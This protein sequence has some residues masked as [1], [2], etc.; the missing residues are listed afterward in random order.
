MK[1]ST[2][3]VVVLSVVCLVSAL[4]VAI[5]DDLTKDAIKLA[6]EKQRLSAVYEVQPEGATNIVEKTIAIPSPL[7]GSS[8]T[9]SY[10]QT[11]KGYVIPVTVPNGY[12]GDISLVL[13]F[14]GDDFW[15]YKVLEH[16]ETPGL[17]ENITGSFIE[18]VK[19]RPIFGTKWAVT[20][21]DG[22]IEPITAATISSRAIC[23][24]I[25]QGIKI[26]EAIE[27]ER[28]RHQ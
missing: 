24:A 15:S 8:A 6:R 14:A 22:D 9:N 18:K 16:S 13:G 19:R 27:I 17:G 3:L 5:A 11:D 1:E 7:D 4:V 23:D 12:A 2:R 10:W 25:G 28:D 26:L 20:K 21:D